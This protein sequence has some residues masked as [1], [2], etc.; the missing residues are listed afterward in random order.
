MEDEIEYN[1]SSNVADDQNDTD[2]ELESEDTSD[3]DDAQEDI[4]AIKAENERLK[5]VNAKLYAR[6][7]KPKAES[8]KQTTQ[9]LS[10][11]EA[12]LIAKGYEDDAIEHAKVIQ[13]GLKAQGKD[14]SLTEVTK[15][16][17]FAS[18]ESNQETKKRREQAQLGA[19]GSGSSSLAKPVSEMTEAE[20]RA[21]F[22]KMQG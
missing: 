17:L 21:Y 13:A 19:S 10:A 7:K 22:K 2:I 3:S 12:R 8:N 6:V 11:D 4:E 15:H 20:H 14:I 16:E 5:K 9:S 1:D 18:W